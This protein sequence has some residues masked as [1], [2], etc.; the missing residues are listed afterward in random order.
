MHGSG[1]SLLKDSSVQRWQVID[2]D[3]ATG[4]RAIDSGSWLLR[5]MALQADSAKS[6]VANKET[7]QD[8]SGMHR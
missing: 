6:S 8:F 3:S 1:A 2:G 7:R 5:S 4:S